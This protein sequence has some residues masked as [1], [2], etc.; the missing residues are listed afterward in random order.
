MG[1]TITIMDAMRR[2]LGE[3]GLLFGVLALNGLAIFAGLLLLVIPGIYLMCRLMVCVPVAIVEGKGPRDSLSRSKQ[4]TADFAGRALVIM[5]LYFVLLVALGL[6]V[7]VPLAFLTQS[8][9]PTIAKTGLT[10]QTFFASVLEIILTPFLYIATSIFYYDL[11]VRKEAFDL[12]MMMDP[13]GAHL[14]STNT[15][16]IASEGR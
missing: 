10:I 16:S 7:E 9:D 2:V 3:L 11:R 14:P 12:H 1:R 8:S 5:V 6:V 15:L 13:D 4:L